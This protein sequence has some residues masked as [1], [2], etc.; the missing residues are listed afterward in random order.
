[1]KT[2]SKALFGTVAAGAMAA[3]SAS[4]AMANDRHRD[5]G[6]DA[7]DVIAGAVILGGIAAVASSVGKDR[8]RDGYR[9][10]DRRYGD[11]RVQRRGNGNRA[12]QK[13]IRNAK[14]DARRGGYRF[15]DVTQIR[16]VERTRYGWRVK[17][18]IAV[19]G[20]RG[21][22]QRA[23]YDDRRYDYG[24]NNGYRQR[25]YDTGKFTCYVERGRV[26]DIDFRG[27]RGLR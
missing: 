21:Y 11:R 14:R 3:S 17:G 19:E 24:Y 12:V 1:M 7:G 22:R 26:A 9:Y 5:R 4:P 10:D 25:A 2:V 27:V 18:R 16:D 15:A 8:Y 23:R 13:C 20:Q 6:V